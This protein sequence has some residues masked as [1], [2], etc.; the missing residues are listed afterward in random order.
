MS[1]DF[2]AVS[3][4]ELSSRLRCTD[5][6]LFVR[7]EFKTAVQNKNYHEVGLHPGQQQSSHRTD[8]KLLVVVCTCR[9]EVFQDVVNLDIATLLVFSEICIGIVLRTNLTDN[10]RNLDGRQS[11]AFLGFGTF[12]GPGLAERLWRWVE[13][14]VGFG[15]C[16]RCLAERWH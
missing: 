2:G 14:L 4:A 12:C 5:I 10:E 15:R 6:G 7:Q 13:Q 8:A 9:A 11:D 16:G 1:P 3:V